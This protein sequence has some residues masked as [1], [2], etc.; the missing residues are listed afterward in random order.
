MFVF[1]SACRF[2][3]ASILLVQFSHAADW[4]MWRCDAS[5]S[6][7]TSQS[8]SR[9]LSFNWSRDLGPNHVAWSEDE[10]LQFDASYQPI[11]AGQT[12]F[13]P[14]SKDDSILALNTRTGEAR[15]QFFADG[16]IRL[17]P[18]ATGGRIYFGSD[19]GYFYCVE[20]DEG[21]LVWRH[22]AAM[23]DRRVLGNER[24]ISLWPAR[25]G[26][27]LVAN[28]MFFTVGVWPFE[29]MLNYQ[30]TVS[31]TSTELPD[32]QTNS[33]NSLSPQGYLVAS[34]GRLFFPGG[35]AT[36]GSIGEDGLPMKHDYEAR[37]QTDWH[38]SAAGPL[39]FH[40]GRVFDVDQQTSFPI[41]APRPLSDGE[42][43]YTA[44]SFTDEE[45]N[46][47]YKLL[48]FAQKQDGN[49][50][51]SGAG[52][53][54]SFTVG[55]E[56][57]LNWDPGVE[58]PSLALDVLADQRLFGHFG[59][60]VFS[61]DLP[62]DGATPQVQWTEKIAGTP[63]T[64]LA[65]DDRLFVVTKEGQ[66]RCYDDT[67]ADPTSHPLAPTSLGPPSNSW[68][69]AVR[70]LTDT[71]QSATGY[72][73]ALGV[74]SGQL[75]D[76]LVRQTNFHIIVI[77]RDARKIEQ[78][79][80]RYAAAELYGTRITALVDEPLH[81]QLPPYMAE[82]VV[83]EA[84]REFDANGHDQWL[85][86]S[87]EALRPYGGTLALFTSTAELREK[88][89]RRAKQDALAGHEAIE[90]PAWLLIRRQG[91]LPGAADWTHEYADGGNSL[92]SQDELV[93][94]P[95]GVLWFGGPAS[96]G[97]HFY[98]RHF[99][100]PSLKVC[101]GR[102]FIQGPTR[103]TAVDIYTGRIF[104]SKE[105]PVG[106]GAG[107]RGN[108]F[109]VE[110][111][112]YH[113]VVNS[114][115]VYVAFNDRCAMLDP[116]TGEEVAKFEL[117]QATDQFGDFRIWKNL[118]ITTVFW[119][120]NQED[121]LPREIVAMDRHSGEIVWSKTAINAVHLV[122]LGGDRVFYVDGLL[123]GFYD[124]WSRQGKVPEADPEQK[125]VALNVETGEQIWIAPTE[126]VVTWLAYTEQ[127]D[128]LVASNKSGMDVL[129]GATGDKLWTKSIEAP[130]FGGHPENV[131]DKVILWGD[132]IIDQRGPGLAYDAESGQQI[133]RPHPTSN[134][135]V[136]WEFTK[137]GHHC[138]YAIANP[139]LLTFR[140]GTAGFCDIASTNTGRLNGFRSGCRNSLI[141]A[142]GVLNAPNY[143]HGCTCSYNLFTSLAL[144]HVPQ[145]DFWSY[146]AV[147]PPDGSLRRMGVN[148]GAP[149]HRQADDGTLWLN[150]PDR[151]QPFD[152]G[153]ILRATVEVTGESPR[154]FRLN[155]SEVQGEDGPAW[156]AAS[157]VEGASAVQ[158]QIPGD[159]S[160][161]SYDASLV[162]VEP[163]A[164]EPGQR[165]FDVSVQ[166]ALVKKSLDIVKETGG[167]H[168][169]LVLSAGQ[170]NAGQTVSVQLDSIRG[171]P[172]ICG[173]RLVAVE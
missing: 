81:T 115:A 41:E 5:R 125:L 1:K 35:R 76:A 159:P 123:H 133:E 36:V 112:G 67:G 146:N 131:W 169:P 118:L 135:T 34:G 126:R 143:A 150:Y 43:I 122:A 33:P 99:W 18:V 137:T 140:A 130:G 93:K 49:Q 65:A 113:Y 7:T 82:L 160:E 173:I 90:T 116:A 117:P 110:K 24:L 138:N 164:A 104:W 145:N 166:G 136:P 91:A 51:P 72:C 57:P 84:P 75:I 32:F 161:H 78:L 149:G 26:P 22:N 62:R 163:T 69:D 119:P 102:M 48:A 105:I 71:T 12:M 151:H 8:L 9:D 38:V 98:N 46:V 85:T 88:L 83:A 152:E 50:D 170:I 63:T 120:A 30:F 129:S 121:P 17:A 39:L 127:H 66:I 172:L 106:S 74:G 147:E 59:Q 55:W 94:A 77:D 139:H 21:Q 37:G 11:V 86:D 27:V 54:P 96:R 16:P 92:M 109:E 134:E 61:V 4:P 3:C 13:V 171:L 100:P 154:W 142:G 23:G 53:E 52:K 58:D 14:S 31:D 10:R 70:E 20:A 64:L 29:G 165:V 162:F 111:P 156:V 103:L 153:P 56:L 2:L 141:P 45:G 42:W 148:L 89:T 108:F 107:R 155:T 40:G 97:E 15:W 167:Q 47:T 60:T 95:L 6:G 132:W 68:A 87:Y 124:A 25:G 73:L 44:R 158:I 114:D 101:D 128:L 157:G 168:R 144:V 79:R 28:Q 19:D 80:R